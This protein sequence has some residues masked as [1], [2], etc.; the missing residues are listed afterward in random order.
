MIHAASWLTEKFSLMM[1]GK[2]FESFV[3]L[4][5]QVKNTSSLELYCPWIILKI[6]VRNDRLRTF[7]RRAAVKS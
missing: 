7:D 1:V 2:I 3:N 6:I 4:N 5:T